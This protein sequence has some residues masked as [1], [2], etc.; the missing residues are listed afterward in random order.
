[1][2]LRRVQRTWERLARTDP[3]WAIL[4]DPAKRGNRWEVGEFFRTGE[5]EIQGVM[6]HLD[7]LGLRPRR[8]RALDFGCGVG[9]LTQALALHF[10]EVHGLDISR[11]MAESARRHNRHGGRC[12]Y[13]WSAA[14]RLP[15][16]DSGFDFVYSVLTLQHMPRRL[17]A[18][19]I[20]ELLR[21]LGP[22]GVLV[23]Q[24]AAEPLAAPGDTGV[25]SR[26]KRLLS[27]AL[28]RGVIE[29]LR[30]LRA[31]VR[32]PSAFEMHGI[33]RDG[34]ERIVRQGGGRIVDVA[35]DRAAGSGWTS[36]RYCALKSDSGGLSAPSARSG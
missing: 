26:L 10:R 34:V 31:T 14:P 2:S 15:F 21:V 28:P 24:E 11:S 16:A 22:G 27:R 33:P 6:D 25:W 9:R 35:E 32:P 17:A 23:F 1:M 36:F 18:G 4:S 29:A 30:G 8:D 19:F 5:E 13:H 12:T 20:G 3:L 7:R